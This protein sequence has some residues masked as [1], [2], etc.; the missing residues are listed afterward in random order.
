MTS[1]LFLSA[2]ATIALLAGCDKP[3]AT[4]AATQNQPPT[5]PQIAK[6][7]SPRGTNVRYALFLNRMRA[8]DLQD[9]LIERAMITEQNE[10]GVVLARSIEADKVADTMRTIVEKMAAEFPGEALTVHAYLASD[11]A[12]SVGV[13]KLDSQTREVVYTP[14][15]K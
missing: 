8:T 15:G 11:P 4:P 2:L 6:S 5:E 3:A 9:P 14:D 7:P 10:I 13:A 12:R 1:R